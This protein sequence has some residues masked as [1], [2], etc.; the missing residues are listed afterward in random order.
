MEI[1]TPSEDSFLITGVL[2]NKI[3]GLIK[4]N[5]DLKFLEIG[6]GSGINLETAL[7]SGVKK[8]NIFSCDINPEAVKHCKKLDFNCIHSDLFKN[9]R[10][11]KKFDI[12][13]FNHPYLPLDKSE[14]K[15]SRTATTGGK[16]GNEVIIKFLK[17]T[18]NH[19]EKNG[20][21]FLITSSLTGNIDFRKLGYKSKKLKSAR[22]FFEELFCR[23]LN[24]LK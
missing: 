3:P 13:A 1:Y 17:Q 16:K 18:K 15:N 8:T 23:E 24:T 14:P 20:K 9:I 22:L 4:R 12:I 21:I 10:K 2:E 5:P 7:N 19:L 6:S 11:D